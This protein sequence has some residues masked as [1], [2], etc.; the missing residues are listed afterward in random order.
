VTSSSRV[1]DA[2][3]WCGLT[4]L[5]DVFARLDL[6]DLGGGIFDLPDAPRPDED[7]PAPVRFLPEY[8]NLVLSH[9]D[10]SRFSRAEDKAFFSRV[11]GLVPFFLVDGQTAGTWRLQAGKVVVTPARP[12]GKHRDA[13]MREAKLVEAF[14][15]TTEARRATSHA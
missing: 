1:A 14:F 9:A 8:D 2:Q 6:V 12:L 3:A 11:N 13:V 15:A 10:R 5:K 4:K 7:V